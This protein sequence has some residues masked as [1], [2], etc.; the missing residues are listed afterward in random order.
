MAAELSSTDMVIGELLTAADAVCRSV[1]SAYSHSFNHAKNVSTVS[2]SKFPLDSLEQCA[3]FLGLKTRD[4]NN[5]KI[6]SNKPT[7]ADRIVLKIESHFET[8]CLDCNQKY[9][10]KLGETPRLTCFL[11]FQGSHNCEKYTSFTDTP[12]PS[13]LGNIWI[14]SGCFKKNDL[15]APIKIRKRSNSGQSVSFVE[16]PAEDED[17]KEESVLNGEVISNDES[18]SRSQNPSCKRYL[19]NACPHGITGK[20]QVNGKTCEEHHPKRCYRYVKEGPKSK[21]GCNKGKRCEYFHPILCKYSVKNRRC[22][23]KE[24]TFVHLRGTKR[25]PESEDKPRTSDDF[26]DNSHTNNRTSYDRRNPP[27]S[28]SNS[29]PQETGYRSKIGAQNRQNS[30]ST[31]SSIGLQNHG[32]K[33]D[34]QNIVRLIQDIRGDFQRELE[35]MRSQ[36]YFLKQPP[37]PP[38]MIPT[39]CFPP[40]LDQPMMNQ[41]MVAA[42]MEHQSMMQVPQHQINQVPLYKD[43]LLRQQFTS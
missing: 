23:N 10:I 14:C 43:M 7:L 2:S 31:H 24:C 4:E 26:I 29:V 17:R 12:N 38:W 11:C 32:Q 27:R 36:M 20:K 1:L 6:Y 9:R 28:R 42:Q 18:E 39:Q 5:G 41:N 16:T 21:R 15:V 35:Q 33:V 19:K 30:H 25:W 37:P 22:T 3:N 8:D 13:P 34:N 40:Q